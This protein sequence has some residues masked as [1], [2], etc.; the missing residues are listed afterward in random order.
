MRIGAIKVWAHRL[1]QGQAIPVFGD[2]Q[3]NRA[4]NRH[5]RKIIAA[6]T[7]RRPSK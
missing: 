2:R 6:R 7:Y 1:L 4:I 3:I 5:V